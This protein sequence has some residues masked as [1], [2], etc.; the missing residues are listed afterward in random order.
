VRFFLLDLGT[1]RV[2]LEYGRVI[3]LDE[4]WFAIVRTCR[5]QPLAECHSEEVYLWWYI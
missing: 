2:M 1:S 3:E 4:G 5:T